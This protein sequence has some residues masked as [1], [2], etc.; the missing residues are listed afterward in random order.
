MLMLIT[1]TDT[2]TPPTD[3]GRADRPRT[4]RNRARKMSGSKQRLDEEAT[5][6]QM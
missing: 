2:D 5:E 3:I 6:I 4:Q 1:Y